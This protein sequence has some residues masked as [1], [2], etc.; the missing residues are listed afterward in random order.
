ME[1]VCRGALEAGGGSLGVL[2]P[3]G[4]EPNRF[5]TGRIVAENLP[6]RLRRLRDLPEAWIFLPRGLG[7]MLELVFVA[8]SIVK[9]QTRPRPIVL[10]GDFWSATLELA[11]GEAASE[12]GRSAL[13]SSL[14]GAATA[15]EAAAAAVLPG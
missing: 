8:E 11:I 14:R 15:S 7:T 10:L 12:E 6:D 5:L 13:R 4:V 1:A 2:L 3:G 9:G